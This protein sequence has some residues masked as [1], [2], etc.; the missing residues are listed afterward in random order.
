MIYNKMYVY[1]YYTCASSRINVCT[2]TYIYYVRIYV[3][4]VYKTFAFISVADIYYNIKRVSFISRRFMVRRAAKKT[5]GVNE[6]KKSTKK[7]SSV[8]VKTSLVTRGCLY[9]YICVRMCVCV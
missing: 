9:I 1:A 8:G 3:C 7:R 4:C 5:G 6:N 2:Y